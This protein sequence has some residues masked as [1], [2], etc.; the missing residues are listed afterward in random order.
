MGGA[1][2]IVGVVLL[3]AKVITSV[4][5]HTRIHCSLAWRYLHALV[6]WWKARGHGITVCVVLVARPHVQGMR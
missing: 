1:T 3:N 2:R 4:A 6:E 5:T